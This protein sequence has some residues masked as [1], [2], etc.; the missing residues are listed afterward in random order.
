[1]GLAD[2]AVTKPIFDPNSPEEL[3]IKTILKDTETI[4]VRVRSVNFLVTALREGGAYLVWEALCRTRG[5]PIETLPRA[6]LVAI[7]KGFM[8]GKE[9]PENNPQMKSGCLLVLATLCCHK[10]TLPGICKQPGIVEVLLKNLLEPHLQ[11]ADLEC[12]VWVLRRMSEHSEQQSRKIGMNSPLMKALCAKMMERI[13]QD[14]GPFCRELRE[15]LDGVGKKQIAKTPR[16]GAGRTPSTATTPSRRGAGTAVALDNANDTFSRSGSIASNASSFG[17]R[18]SSSARPLN[19]VMSQSQGLG[20]LTSTTVGGGGGGGGG[21]VGAG[22]GKNGVGASLASSLPIKATCSDVGGGATRP[23]SSMSS[24]KSSV[25]G[26]A[27]SKVPRLTFAELEKGG[28][29]PNRLDQGGGGGFFTSRSQQMFLAPD[30][31]DERMKVEGNCS[32][33]L[34]CTAK[35]PEVNKRIADSVRKE[36][37]EPLVC[38]LVHGTQWARGH[39]CRAIGNFSAEKEFRDEIAGLPNA[40]REK[41]L[42]AMIDLMSDPEINENRIYATMAIG[43]VVMADNVARHFLMMK[44]GV[45]ALQAVQRSGGSLAERALGDANRAM[46]LLARFRLGTSHVSWMPESRA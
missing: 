15:G 40:V 41:V 33:V 32:A 23:G 5:Q 42:Q 8:P 18:P 36:V 7:I 31:L 22:T 26:S 12:V 39:A 38:V 25:G 14:F 17:S 3:A 13:K 10:F 21:G 35:I 16:R 46:G 9:G 6:G 30:D 34:G 11:L 27:S 1:M 4:M 45:K 29:T 43:N 19:E 44:D 2:G 28:Q 37:L 24:S 20:R